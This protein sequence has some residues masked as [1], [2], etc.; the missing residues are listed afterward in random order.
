MKLIL[1]RYEHNM[2]WLKDYPEAEVIVYDRSKEPMEGSIPVKNIGSDWHDKFSFI[3]DNY[4]NLPN[5]A[6]Y[7]KANLFKYITKEEFD[8]VKD[9]TTFTPLLTQHHKVYEPICRYKDG[10]YEEI[11]NR[12]YLHPHPCKDENVEMEL[13][14]ILGLSD[15]EYI[16]FAPGSSY[17]LPKENILKH[18]KEFYQKLRS[19]LEWDRYPG[20]AQ[21]I[22]RGAYYLWR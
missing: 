2:D 14:V 15:K 17:I 5:V 20:E 3:I 8:K 19:Y 1:S 11:N 7:A 13:M 21:L 12:Y 22:E 6:I 10:M 4:D 9:N 18:S 16:Q